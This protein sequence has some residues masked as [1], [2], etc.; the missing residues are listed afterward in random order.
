MYATQFSR[1]FQKNQRDLP[2]KISRLKIIASFTTKMCTSF[3]YNLLHQLRIR[4]RS[5]NVSRHCVLNSY[6]EIVYRT[7]G[8]IERRGVTSAIPESLA[9]C[10]VTFSRMMPLSPMN[11]ISVC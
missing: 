6:R 1:K 10:H 8:F 11:G 2:C 5:K 9:N 3:T 4:N 7:D